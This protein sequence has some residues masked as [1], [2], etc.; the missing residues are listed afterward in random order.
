MTH[1][2]ASAS[3][4]TIRPGH[5]WVIEPELRTA[6]IFRAKS[7]HE[8]EDGILTIPGSPIRVVL[9]ELFAELDPA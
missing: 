7:M 9:G 3:L 1:S 6:Y 5:A 8:P 4:L 2:A